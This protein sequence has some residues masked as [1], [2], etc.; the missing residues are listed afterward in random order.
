V[1]TACACSGVAVLPVPITQTGSYARTAP[2]ST[3]PPN[4]SR[5]AATCRPTTSSVTPLSRSA[6]VSPTQMIG[7][8]PA[9][10]T[11]FA[12]SATVR[13]SSQNNCLRSE[14]PTITYRQPNSRSIPAD[15]SPVN[16]P[17]EYW[18]T[19]WAPHASF[20]P[21]NADWVW[22]RYGKGTQTAQV[23]LCSP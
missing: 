20:D 13:S 6:S 17:L 21:A 11:A 22:A 5:T 4:S 19:F 10:S 2:F 15:T 16:A 14:C 8:I 18:L 9:A 23:A 3:S 1:C 7:T 12:L